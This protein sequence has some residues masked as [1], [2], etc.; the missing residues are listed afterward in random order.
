MA[1]LV[2]RTSRHSLLAELAEGIDRRGRCQWR[3][4]WSLVMPRISSF[5]G[6]VILMYFDDHN[7]PHF[8]A[9]YGESQARIGISDL[10][11]MDEGLPSRALRLV[12][13]WAALHRDELMQNWEKARAGVPLDKIEPL[14]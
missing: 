2:N 13:E 6:I 9:E 3:G 8:H 7:P 14:A 11:L 4:V 1:S 5:Y 12:L 10:E